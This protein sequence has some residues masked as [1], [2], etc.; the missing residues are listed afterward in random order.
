MITNA[1]DDGDG[2]DNGNDDDDGG[3]GDDAV[4]DDTHRNAT[5]KL[6]SRSACAP[7]MYLGQFAVQ[8]N[9]Q[10]SHEF[11]AFSPSCTK[12]VIWTTFQN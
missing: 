6:C 8:S 10:T 2:D 3:G 11:N 9:R 1:G 12:G 7:A 4:N 5:M